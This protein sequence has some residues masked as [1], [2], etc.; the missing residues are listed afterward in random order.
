MKVVITREIPD[1]AEKLLKARGFQVVVYRKDDPV[2]QRELEKLVKDA[3]G[4]ISL[5][6]EKFDKNLIDKLE[7]CKIIANYA[8]GY[9]NID[10]EYAKSKKIAITNTPDVLTDATADIA[11]SLVLACSRRIIEGV[12]F[13]RA[14]KFKGWKPKLLLGVEM[15][16][17][18][19]GI[20][21]AGRIGSAVARRAKAF[22]A[23]ILYYDIDEVPEL[24]K[25]TGAKKVSLNFI[26][27][28]SDF[29]S[30]HLPFTPKTH[31]L[32]DKEHLQ[33]MKK[34]SILINTARGEIVDEKELI[35]MLKAR[36]IFAA[37]FDV[38]EGE[39][40]VNPAL[41]K[42]GNVV[43]LPHIGSATI[44]AR[45]RMAMLAAG[46]VI[47]VLTGREPLTPVV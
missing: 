13:M 3:D 9:N 29:V 31:H 35:A 8:V 41:F 4:I 19:F 15:S 14:R 33:M 44:E 2:P 18:F 24:E 5:L 39:P 27:R 26:L 37:G 32:L 45:N 25:E 17:K 16:G 42:L 28:K 23:N 30:I 7:R 1:S 34:T 10:I 43:L 22:G 40:K 21:G 11:I 38:Y 20:L 36:K 47:A 12:K 46:N 6:T